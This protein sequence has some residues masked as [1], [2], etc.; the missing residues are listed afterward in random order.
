ML[1]NEKS[2]N[3]LTALDLSGMSLARA[4]CADEESPAPSP[5]SANGIPD[6]SSPNPTASAAA[7]P[8]GAAALAVAQAMCRFDSK[9][10]DAQIETIA[11]GIDAQKVAGARLNP[12]KRRLRNSD[13]PVTT[14]VVAVT[15]A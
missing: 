5:F 4:G 12:K 14:F 8:C 1:S 9:L 3:V 13:E 7:K 15:R 6:E 2:Q 11:R 10:T